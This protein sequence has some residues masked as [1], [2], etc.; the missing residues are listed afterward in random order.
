VLDS[1][2]LVSA[3]IAPNGRISG[4]LRQPLRGR[5]QLCLSE[6]IVAETAATLLTKPSVRSYAEYADEDVRAYLGWLLRGARLVADLPDIRVVPDDPDDD[7]VVATAL[8]A[9]AEY[10]V[11]GDRHLLALGSYQG[12]AM[13]K[14]ARFL[15]V[16]DAG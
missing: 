10:L 12:V 7:M 1:S 15:E 11:T 8:V 5:Y 2:V 3:F 6:E 4:L 9:Q 14:P 13:L 16:L